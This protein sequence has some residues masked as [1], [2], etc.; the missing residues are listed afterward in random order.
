MKRTIGSRVIMDCFEDIMALNIPVQDG[1]TM[2]PHEGLKGR[3][4][5]IPG[6]LLT[7][8]EEEERYT[9]P[10]IKPYHPAK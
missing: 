2:S 5:P 7:Q 8:E 9:Q 1:A 4:P 10:P 3:P 6:V